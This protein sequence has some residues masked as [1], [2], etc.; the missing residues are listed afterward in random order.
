[1]RFFADGP[2][3]P[4]E[5]L[6]A[7]DKGDVVFL[8]GAGV[9]VP[10]G[11]PNFEQ[12]ARLIAT[13]LGATDAPLVRQLY[14]NST[15]TADPAVPLD[16]VF[17][18]LQKEYGVAQVERLTTR[19][20]R[21]P[22]KA[23][24]TNHRTI[25]RLSSDVQ[26]RPRLVT[27]NFDL[28]F[29]AA[30]KR[31]KAFVPPYLPDLEYANR[32]DGLVYLH[33]RLNG[34]SRSTEGLRGLV[35]GIGDMGR[36]YLADGWAT[37]FMNQLISRYTVVLLGYSANDVPIRYLLEGLNARGSKPKLFAFAEGD[38]GETEERWWD[39]GVVAIPYAATDSHHSALW[40]TLS[41]WAERAESI[42]RWHAKTIELARQG[43]RSLLPH[44]R[45]Q[46]A[47]MALTVTGAAAI[48]DAVPPLPAEWLCVFDTVIRYGR[49]EGGWRQ[50]QEDFDPLKTYRL[51]NDPPRI[52]ASNRNTN[53]PIGINILEPLG[54]DERG[55]NFT[56]L[57]GRIA[58]RAEPLSARLNHLCR[59]IAANASQ[60]TLVWW[61]GHHHQMHHTLESM[62]SWQLRRD[63]DVSPVVRQA[64]TIYFE[65][66]QHEQDREHRDIYDLL[67]VIKHEGWSDSTLRLVR[68]TLEPYLSVRP[69]T[70]HPGPPVSEAEIG[71]SGIMSADVKFNQRSEK[72]DFPAHLL[73]WFVACLRNCLL[74]AASI[75]RDLGIDQFSRTPTLHHED[76]P[77]SVHLDDEASF[78]LWFTELFKRLAENDPQAASRELTQ[79]PL[80]DASYFGKLCIWAWMLPSVAP[81]EIAAEGLITIPEAP[82]WRETHQR[83]LMWT[84]RAR[85]P[86]FTDTQ[87]FS[88]EE[89]ILAGP[90]KWPN[91]EE[92]E[93]Q[94][95]RKR[96]SAIRLGWMLQNG[97]DV[98][99]S[100]LDALLDLRKADP[101]WRPSWDQHADQSFESRGGMVRTDTDATSIMDA[102]LGDV[103][104]RLGA[105]ER[106]PAGGFVER[107]PFLGL[108]QKR[109]ARALAV[110]THEAKKQNYPERL[111]RT[112]F[113]NDMPQN[114]RFRWV[115]A[116][117]LAKLPA[118]SIVA[119]SRSSCRWL[120]DRMPEFYER[121]PQESLEVW[122]SVFSALVEAGEVATT[123]GM[124][125]VS[126]AGVPQR[127]SRRTFGH[128]INGPIGELTEAL[129]QTLVRLKPTKKTGIAK[130]LKHRLEATLKTP[131]EGADH[132]TAMICLHLKWLFWLDPKWTTASLLPLLKH[133]H[134]LA[135]PAWSG[136]LYDNKLPQSELFKLIK[137]D[138]LAAFAASRD[139]RWEDQAAARL[140][141]FMVVA[142]VGSGEKVLSPSEA[143]RALQSADDD[144][145]TA[146][147]RQLSSM[148]DGA[149]EWIAKGKPFVEKVWPQELRFQT[150]ATSSVFAHI[151]TKAA[152]GFP[153]VVQKVAD[154]L[155]PTDQLDMLIHELLHANDDDSSS[156]ATRYPLEAVRLLELLMSDA[157][158]YVPYNLREFL[159]VTSDHLP[160]L[161]QDKAWRRLNDLLSKS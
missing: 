110:L 160:E 30:G 55:A 83:E 130:P 23:D 20:L 3:I 60:P 158:R 40:A 149:D 96:T 135:E 8:C 76:K 92:E 134:P 120:Q 52:E 104:A 34:S 28:L 123:S 17:G 79:W 86:D 24:V 139:W 138:Y 69:P 13:E 159:R 10:A 53:Q 9:S 29:E 157:P 49:V 141:Q 148:V 15:S 5:L 136:F 124:G 38:P 154:L 113:N 31:L 90:Y 117:R 132:A 27:T 66:S 125:D 70:F 72:L 114:H 94:Q 91:E 37:R 122:D 78:F 39:R 81:S 62:I 129:I 6:E 84:I 22:K 131:G 80:D 43:P 151:A 152:E 137:D 126:I 140:S 16:Q 1:M 97:L 64:W 82:F 2:D 102:P 67:D 95:R 44:E 161:R 156:I 155:Q 107:N 46:I 143:R 42:D 108:Y 74:H 19:M 146:A 58:R 147:L 14:R 65:A 153:A 99:K 116:R 71:L 87:R 32:L 21:T 73:P 109:P 93:Y 41:A 50:D 4:L 133:D 26:G 12:L 112:L 121:R 103:L 142:T 118:A 45:G 47:S 144:A 18:Y 88:I 36:A 105:V 7:R 128:A 59:W 57:A 11:M 85:W 61:A 51:D 54:H 101:E 25:L 106:R 145:R 48:A 33:G 119:L 68:R 35:L 111:W 75:K 115:V 89:R 98:R 56:R 63:K 150:T 77:G 100:T 127:R